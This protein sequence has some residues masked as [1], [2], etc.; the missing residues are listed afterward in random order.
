MLKS[1]AEAGFIVERG[2]GGDAK[3]FQQ[4][5]FDLWDLYDRW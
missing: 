1:C 4:I 5:D 3:K 2:G